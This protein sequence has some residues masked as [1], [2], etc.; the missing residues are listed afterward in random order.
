[1][2]LIA[3]AMASNLIAVSNTEVIWAYGIVDLIQL[4]TI[5][6]HDPFRM[7]SW[8]I[9]FGHPGFRRAWTMWLEAWCSSTP[10]WW[11]WMLDWLTHHPANGIHQISNDYCGI[12]LCA[13]LQKSGLKALYVLLSVI[14][15]PCYRVAS[16]YPLR[17][18]S[19]KGVPLE[20]LLAIKVT[21]TSSTQRTEGRL[22]W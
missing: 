9:H 4:M 14:D 8:E 16:P 1:M 2:N 12:V 17:S 18:W 19:L 3:A 21:L 5:V 15:S 7:L 20:S 22:V 11:C 6:D 13:L 10:L